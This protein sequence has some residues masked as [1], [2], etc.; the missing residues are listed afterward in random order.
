VYQY[1][2]LGTLLNYQYRIYK[3]ADQQEAALLE[4]EN[5]F[6]IVILTALLAIRQKKLE[7]PELL[8]LK[9]ELA[10]NLLRRKI[11]PAKI[12]SLMEFLKYY[13]HFDNQENNDKFEKEIAQLTDNKETMGIEE[14]L[15][16]RAKR[17]GI[18]EGIQE[19]FA[20]AQSIFVKNLLHNTDFPIPKIA[21]LANVSE[22]F[23]RQVKNQ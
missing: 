5:P 15:L 14:F 1:H 18:K 21:N 10:R 6:A 23:V 12:R 7:D 8:K 17:Q 11:P 20:D 13:V 22:D 9:L 3:I 19:G 16:D 2:C 4:N